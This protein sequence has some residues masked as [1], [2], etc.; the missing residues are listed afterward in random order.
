M[1]PSQRVR[2]DCS[3]SISVGKSFFTQYRRSLNW[4]GEVGTVLMIHMRLRG[5]LRAL[6]FI[7]FIRPLSSFSPI[8]RRTCRCGPN[9]SLSIV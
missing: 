5:R 7:I 2:G 4:S 1:E 6:S 8:L 3:S 9:E